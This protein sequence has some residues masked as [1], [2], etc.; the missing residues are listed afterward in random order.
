MQFLPKPATEKKLFQLVSTALQESSFKEMS[1]YALQVNALNFL[2]FHL[3]KFQSLAVENYQN[4]CEKIQFYLTQENSKLSHCAHGA[5]IA[6]QEVMANSL[7]GLISSAGDERG[8]A[9]FVYLYRN[10]FSTFL[11]SDAKPKSLALAIEGLG[12]LSP[13]CASFLGASEVV[14]LFSSLLQKCKQ[15]RLSVLNSQNNSNFHNSSRWSDMNSLYYYPNLVLSL[16]TIIS[17][18]EIADLNEVVVSQL[19]S[20]QSFCTFLIGSYPMQLPPQQKVST[21]ALI[22]L[23][24]ALHLRN[25]YFEKFVDEFWVQ[26]LL[27]S[28]QHPSINVLLQVASD[29]ADEKVL[30]YKNYIPLLQAIIHANSS[31]KNQYLDDENELLSQRFSESLRM[32][33]LNAFVRIIQLLNLRTVRK[34]QTEDADFLISGIEEMVPEKPSD[35]EIFVNLVAIFEQIVPGLV[36]TSELAEKQFFVEFLELICGLVEMYS[37]VSGIYKLLTTLLK[38][39]ITANDEEV[40]S[41]SVNNDVITSILK[42]VA[43]FLKSSISSFSDEI[44]I[45]A[46]F[47]LFAMPVEVYAV[48][49]KQLEFIRKCLKN[50]F[51]LNYLPLAKSALEV[52]ETL[53][54]A[55]GVKY[56][57]RTDISQTLQFVAPALFPYLCFTDSVDNDS[58][59]LASI[60]KVQSRSK[61]QSYFKSP[62]NSAEVDPKEMRTFQEKLFV[63]LSDA[64]IPIQK[65]FSE[66]QKSEMDTKLLSV[67]ANS[68]SKIEF[69]LPFKDLRPVITFDSIITSVID[70]ARYSTNRK[71]KIAACE[72]LHSLCLLIIGKNAQTRSSENL[73][74]FVT[75]FELL[76]P[77][78]IQLAADSDSI[79]NQL[80]A[81][82]TLQSVH[83]FT[84]S[85]YQSSPETL[86]FVSAIFDQLTSGQSVK[87]TIFAARCLTEV[88]EWSIK[89]CPRD[90]D[91]MKNTRIKQMCKLI[92]YNARN[93]KLKAK[94]GALVA[95]CACKRVI[96]EYKI[97]VDTFL[98]EW[99]LAFLD[100]LKSLH[101]VAPSDTS[102]MRKAKDVIEALV[103]I[104]SKYGEMFRQK[105]KGRRI[106]Y[107]FKDATTSEML[108]H[109]VSQ[110]TSPET[111]Y[112]RSVLTLIGTFI[113]LAGLSLPNFFKT[114]ITS[115][116]LEIKNSQVDHAVQRINAGDLDQSLDSKVL[117]EFLNAALGSLDCYTWAIANGK[118]DIL[119]FLSD[120][121]HLCL[122]IH[123][124][125][126]FMTTE[127]G[128]SGFREKLA[129]ENYPLKCRLDELSSMLITSLF[130]FINLINESTKG[131]NMSKICALIIPANFSEFLSLFVSEPAR[132][133][134]SD[135]SEL[136]EI[137]VETLRHMSSV[138]EQRLPLESEICSI[139]SLNKNDKTQKYLLIAKLVEET[140]ANTKVL[141]N[142]VKSCQL[143]FQAFPSLYSLE[144]RQN[145]SKLLLELCYQ[146]IDELRSSL[147]EEILHFAFDLHFDASQFVSFVLHGA[148]SSNT[149]STSNSLSTTSSFMS[150]CNRKMCQI[151]VNNLSKCLDHVIN[152]CK[153]SAT[154]NERTILF[155][156][157]SCASDNWF[158]NREKWS[159]DNLNRGQNLKY[160]SANLDSL[161]EIAVNSKVECFEL[162]INICRN[163]VAIDK[164]SVLSEKSVARQILNVF[165]FCLK[166]G[167]I[168]FTAKIDALELLTYLMN[169][170][171]D[172]NQEVNA[173]LKEFLIEDLVIEDGISMAD[174][175]N[176][177][178]GSALDRF[179]LVEKSFDRLFHALKST[180]CSKLLDTLVPVV[181]RTSNFPFLEKFQTALCSIGS[182]LKFRVNETLLLLN[183]SFQ[184]CLKNY[185]LMPDVRRR[186]FEQVFKVLIA[187]CASNI[188]K[189]FFFDK[190]K[191]LMEV[192]DSSSR[193]SAILSQQTSIPD[194]LLD[195]EI[196]FNTFN[197]AIEIFKGSVMFSR[198]I[199]VL[200]P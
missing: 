137:L 146:K 141:T 9:I 16:A 184:L 96:R 125:V 183:K 13:F 82:L 104:Y 97:V 187:N 121:K 18:N 11:D 25:I 49:D 173:T 45:S 130:R 135:I 144:K 197:C 95:F 76:F 37:Y 52:M 188:F 91:L 55:S 115:G 158:T 196:V 26:V 68:S 40:S 53:I 172:I 99:M 128:F 51:G 80:F 33:M 159:S 57:K 15:I 114:E 65:L 133:I 1:R 149:L 32:S 34:Q 142:T 83:W 148:N 42:P 106:P 90:E 169:V 120:G 69:P 155:N 88:F 191:L 162:L 163:L 176:L 20:L 124:F 160:F 67:T 61:I 93:P 143:S 100:L 145:I 7:P 10:L 127:S 174:R 2:K 110:V 186:V 116:H 50:A 109:L 105:S 182:S 81:P 200:V 101:Y 43:L 154:G 167:K 77:A 122:L 164:D 175:N 112:R 27:R 198:I 64:N 103:K 19:K 132:F 4:L 195:V 38:L 199:S 177:T 14:T 78:I 150:K 44:L 179:A 129:Q 94:S 139:F 92:T 8:K 185:D 35:V 70:S 62:S 84:S 17:T 5:M 151:F 56:F 165:N 54:S 6:F 21:R 36:T 86:C 60:R 189:Q 31:D 66:L 166:E 71:C 123:C 24:K 180:S 12:K 138:P 152:L 147:L 98:F 75:I 107:K 102:L 29:T 85:K 47:A 153:E 22:C 171:D 48:I 156:F 58:Q 193:S 117:F 134:S 41:S 39:V 170:E 73:D 63:F 89:H 126:K 108:K 119:K 157:L 111:E 79:A 30:S 72:L 161:S 87:V 23:L 28:C 74:T 118:F 136:D 3:D 194:S 192:L 190:L 131:K 168:Q 113:P 140:L 181:C 178:L 46:L 59:V